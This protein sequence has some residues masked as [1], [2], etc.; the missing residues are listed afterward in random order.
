MKPEEAAKARRIE[1]R[2]LG[3]SPTSGILFVGVN[4]KAGEVPVFHIWVGCKRD[5]LDSAVAA[6]VRS[7]LY[8]EIED[9]LQVQIEVHRGVVREIL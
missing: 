9:G 5:Y 4:I 1:A 2:L 7:T 6:L 3:L 8:K